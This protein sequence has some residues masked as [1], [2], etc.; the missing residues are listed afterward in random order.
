MSSDGDRSRSPKGDKAKPS[1]AP[2]GE[3]KASD[4]PSTWSDQIWDEICPKLDVKLDGFQQAFKEDVK[5]V[6]NTMVG[7]HVERLDKKIEHNQQTTNTNIKKLEKQMDG[8]FATMEE[9]L[10]KA[11][12]ASKPPEPPAPSGAPGPTGAAPSGIASFSVADGVARYDARPG[13]ATSPC[14]PWVNDVTTPH[15][16]R[17]PDATKL[18]C[19]VHDRVQV[20]K[21]K[22][23]ENLLVLVAEAGLKESDFTL[24]GDALDY[25]FEMQ[26][27]GD[28]RFAPVKAQQFLSSLS[29]G[30]G[31]YKP[32][33][34]EC[35]ENK[36]HKFYVNP[37][38]NPAQTRKEV[39]AKRL[40]TIISPMRADKEFFVKKSSGS[41][42]C[43][44]RVVATVFLTGEESARIDWCHPKRIELKLVQEDIEAAFSHYVVA[45]RPSS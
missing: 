35:A 43:E 25:R 29:L 27:S 10:L 24:V 4:D 26:F 42:Y 5:K 44:S 14:P 22:F 39:L 30:R 2:G 8:K 45:G 18:F 11:I 32:Q 13:V 41:I 1:K 40:Q 19:N 15:F 20:A 16:N 9:N 6:V 38:K 37:D 17:I 33:F 36:Q 34:V 28:A 7:K 31:R 21:S 12:Q 3:D 23:R